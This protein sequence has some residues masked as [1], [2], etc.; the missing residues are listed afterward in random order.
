MKILELY[1]GIGGMHFS[2][3]ESG[4]EGEV[5]ASVDINQTANLVYGHNFKDTLLLNRN[6]QSLTF[7]YINSLEV[8]TILMSPP[9]QPF[10]RNG[11]QRDVNDARTISFMHI[12][13]ILQ[14]LNI[15]NIL[16]ENVKGF[17]SSDMRDLFI[18]KLK[19]CNFQ[20]QEF[21]LSPTQFGIP[22]TRCRY[23][24][25]AK[26]QPA[27]LCFE[28]GP[29]MTHHPTKTAETPYVLS[30]IVDN[31]NVE[32]YLLSDTDL[33]KR[34]IALDICFKTCT[35]SCCFTKSYGR[36]VTGT[37][38]VYTDKTKQELDYVYRSL[39][40]LKGDREGYLSCI[41]QLRLRFFTPKEVCRL[42]SFPDT[43]EFPSTVTDKQKY[44]L[45]GNSINVRVVSELIKL[46]NDPS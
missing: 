39:D 23:Y 34:A 18:G 17:E 44:M 29:L 33:L 35:R 4:L 20:Y 21:L 25:L 26:K 24:C 12:I 2:F 7:E 31:G 46:L 30:E 37:G 28:C 16:M 32:R 36:Y 6:I 1:S 9:C 45:L 3:K 13:N 43:F 22:N 15:R 42:M 8:D 27:K 14:E 40:S 38:S 41:R 11:L 19:E 10:T 5:I